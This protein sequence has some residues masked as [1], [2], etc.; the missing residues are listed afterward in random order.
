MDKMCSRCTSASIGAINCVLSPTP[1]KSDMPVLV[2]S[3]QPNTPV[4]EIMDVIHQRAGLSEDNTVHIF[5]DGRLLKP[6]WV[7]RD[8]L[9]QNFRIV[10]YLVK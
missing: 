7:L 9:P 1:I 4:G 6:D 10:Q 8:N 3:V 2:V 5:V